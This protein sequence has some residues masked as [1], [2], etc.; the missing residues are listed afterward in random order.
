MIFSSKLLKRSTPISDFDSFYEKWKSRGFSDDHIGKMLVELEEPEW[1]YRYALKVLHGR[2]PEGETA[3]ASDAEW[4][5]CYALNVL[6]ARF[7]E[8]ETAIASDPEWSYRYALN[9]LK[10]SVQEAEKW[11]PGL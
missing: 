4:S 9:V 10:L 6:H 7:P 11:K 5:Y 1:S 8:G 2:F 3:I